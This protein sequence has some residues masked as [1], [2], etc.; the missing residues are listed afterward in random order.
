MDIKLFEWD[1]CKP[2]KNHEA[3]PQEV[4]RCL[5]IGESGCG[6]TNILLNLL[7]ND[8]WLDY[9]NLMLVGSSL[10]QGKYKI[11]IEGFNNGLNKKAIRTIFRKQKKIKEHNIDEI[12][13]I[14]FTGEGL[15]LKDTITVTYYAYHEQIPSPPELDKNVKTAI[16]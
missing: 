8:G 14:K 13:L 15:K 11:L 16:V 3:L 2:V 5:L 12:K 10:N 9:D 1:D 4:F 7:L 6:K